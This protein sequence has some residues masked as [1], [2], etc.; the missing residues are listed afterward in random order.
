M[1]QPTV[2]EYREQMTN[3]LTSLQSALE[4]ESGHSQRLN[5]PH[6]MNK[7]KNNI[8]TP[9]MRSNSACNLQVLNR[10]YRHPSETFMLAVS[11]MDRF[12]SVVKARP[13]H[14]A[15]VSVSCYHIAMKSTVR[16]QDVV[17]TS[18]LIRISQAGCTVSDLHRM[19]RIILEKLNW[20][21]DAPTPLTFLHMFYTL[22]LAHGYLPIKDGD[23]RF[24]S[25]TWKLEACVC[26]KAF[27]IFKASTLALSLLSC[28]IAAY[29]TEY[30]SSVSWMRATLSLQL[31]T[32]I[33]D[34]ELLQ[35]RTLVCEFLELYSSPKS[36]MPRSK[37]RWIISARTAKQLQFS[38]QCITG[39]PTIH[40]N[41]IYRAP[42][43][44]EDSCN[45]SMEEM[46]LLPSMDAGDYIHCDGVKDEDTTRSQ[47]EEVAM[48][49]G[50]DNSICL[51]KP[52][53]FAYKNEDSVLCRFQKVHG[54]V[55]EINVKTTS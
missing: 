40:E 1:A 31:L 19:Q 29:T 20:N 14:M 10:F 50:R 5:G 55:P 9:E 53:T 41:Q 11:I 15:C 36:K 51:D 38:A 48:D 32:E 27:T 25:L 18:D 24:Q 54:C 21:L 8:V 4:K 12:L 35:C 2:S 33:T 52:L 23:L 45:S 3:L 16:E 47:P 7:E 49:T 37:L 13:H 28:E 17:P 44:D 39:L 43:G 22:A 34:C 30:N 46:Q 6:N 26:H 42:S